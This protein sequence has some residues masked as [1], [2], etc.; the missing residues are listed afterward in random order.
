M[1]MGLPPQLEFVA[2]LFRGI[3]G[4]YSNASVAAMVALDVL[5]TAPE[6]AWSGISAATLGLAAAPSIAMWGVFDVGL[7]LLG[8]VAT[9]A[10]QKLSGDSTKNA[11]ELGLASAF[12]LAFPSPC[13][14]FPSPR[15]SFR[16]SACPAPG[17][18]TGR[19]RPARGATPFNRCNPQS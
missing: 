5:F 1:G 6:A 16:A 14:P 15:R 7:M 12:F 2:N 17:R 4:R 19:H 18:R 8:F 10:L 13:S 3:V 9:A 11:L